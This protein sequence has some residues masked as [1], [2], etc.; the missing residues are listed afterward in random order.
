MNKTTVSNRELNQAALASLISMTILFLPALCRA[1]DYTI[2]TV[3]GGTPFASIGCAQETDLEGDGCPATSAEMGP[4][5]IAVDTTGNLYIADSANNLIRKVSTNGLISTIA[6]NVTNIDGGY[7]GDGGP[8]TGA[9]V[10]NPGGLALDAAGNLYIA[11]TGNLRIRKI[12]TNG[13]ITTVAG[14]G[15][16]CAQ[17]TNLV[18][19]GCPATSAILFSPASV[20]VDTAG[21]LYIADTFNQRIRH[22]A[23]GGTITTVAGNG[24]FTLLASSL[25]DGGP[26]TSA[27]LNFPAGVSVDSLGNVYVGDTFNNRIRK[28][29]VNGIINTIA[30]SGSGSYSGD[31]GPATIAGLSSPNGVTVDAAGNLYIADTGD[32]R[33][34]EVT[35]NGTITTIAGDGDIGS[36]G[37]GGPATSATLN[38]PIAVALGDGGNIFVSDAGTNSDPSSPDDYRVRLLTPPAGSQAPT[39]TFVQNAEG[40]SAIIAPNTW[41]AIDGSNLAPVGDTRIWE[42]SDFVNNQM[43]TQLDGVGVSMNGES[44]YVYYISPAQVNVLTPLDLAAGNVQ[45]TVTRGG[46]TSASFTAEAK[47]YSPS[48]FIFGAGPYVVATHASGALLGPT[49]LY[50]G[51]TTPAAPG[52][53][54]VL[55]ANSFGPVSPAVVAGSEAQSG[56][57]PSSPVID[58]GGLPAS[59]QFAGLVSPG[60]YQ[61]NVVVPSSA[62]DG[63]DSIT[64]QYNGFTTQSGVL[65]TVQQ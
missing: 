40:G 27:T 55:Y 24:S 64:A 35:A 31:G 41:V 46:V 60:L 62:P 42:G 25:G 6:G 13:I 51:L 4:A 17:Q 39:V 52:E 1:Q 37:D 44:A 14:G 36:T 12:A 20:A 19:D 34:R 3:A 16:G 57:L 61:F 23:P 59:V 26:A 18:G 48:F 9:E 29:T 21:N 49:S 8:S 33:V 53:V 58:I 30:G 5:G 32:Q 10:R 22:V 45:V 2:T 15:S 65:L 56:D 28:V 50:P 63:D 43:P 54:V 11:D 47:A 7:S 38:A